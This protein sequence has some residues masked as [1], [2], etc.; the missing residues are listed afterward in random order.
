MCN[1]DKS[2]IAQTGESVVEQQGKYSASVYKRRDG[3][4]VVNVYAGNALSPCVVALCDE[5]DL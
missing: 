1:A 2:A 3:Q 4:M 5:F